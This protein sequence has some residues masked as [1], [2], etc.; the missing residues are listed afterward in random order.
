MSLAESPAPEVREEGTPKRELRGPWR[1][2]FFAF[3]IAAAGFHLYTGAFGL[4][5]THVQVTV[6]WAFM[7]FLIL[8]LY[9]M[10]P[11]HDGRVW[12]DVLLGLGSIGANLYLIFTIDNR[13]LGVGIPSTLELLL[14][15]LIC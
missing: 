6:H 4:L 10:T 9:K 8:L 3:V 14:G 13:M 1:L 12:F 7:S 2:L 11:N 5:A 15:G